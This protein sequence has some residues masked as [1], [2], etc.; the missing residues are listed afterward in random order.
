MI[1]AYYTHEDGKI[2]QFIGAIDLTTGQPF[3][4][5]L[6]DDIAT[7]TLDSKYKELAGFANMTWH[8]SDRFDIT[9]GARS[10]KND[11]SSTQDSASGL[12]LVGTDVISTKS[13]ES[14][15]TYSISP[16]FD[17]SDTTAVYARV[18][19][20]YRP[21]GPNVVPPLS[22]PSV[23]RTF[24]SD[25]LTSY[26]LGLKTDIGRRLSFDLSAYHL[27]WKD[28]QL[29]TSIQN[30]NV[31]ING[32]TAVSNGVEGSVNW[33]PVRG[34]Q[35]G[36]NGAYIDAHLTS[37]T[38]FIVGGHDGDTLPWVPKFSFSL[39]SDYE[40]KLSN[41]TT[42]Y[43]GGTLAYTGKQRDNFVLLGASPQRHIPDYATIDLRAGV[44]FDRFT[45]EAY[46]KNLT[47]SEGIGSLSTI[48]SQI[49]GNNILPNDA[50]RA[51]LTR[52]RTI[53]LS[54]SAG[55]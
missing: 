17:I 1:G 48:D 25:T 33:R 8:L 14:V 11:Q 23:P 32:G 4:I 35:V 45:I 39:T 22:P 9:A 50:I 15:L 16:R 37:D 41:S 38:P 18:A 27:S 19:K 21:G 34:L 24:D 30:V 12:G 55:F 46:V 2:D 28:I 53:G 40:W 6:L 49:T 20:G 52:P 5:P 47:D 3:G 31:N 54:L 44:D 13:H 51:A 43:V 36:L 29:I 42:A 10:A 7:L 26:E